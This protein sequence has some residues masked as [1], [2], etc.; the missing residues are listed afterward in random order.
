[1]QFNARVFG[2]EPLFYRGRVGVARFPPCRNLAAER[3]PVGDAPGQALTAQHAD[4]ALGDVQPGAVFRRMMNLETLAEPAGLVRRQSAVKTHWL[5]CVKVVH[6]WHDFFAGEVN[7]GDV[8]E[9]LSE[10]FFRPAV[11]DLDVPWPASGA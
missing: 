5:M 6:G 1:M 8:P 10:I 4:S 3:F 2:G 9:E 11:G 7:V